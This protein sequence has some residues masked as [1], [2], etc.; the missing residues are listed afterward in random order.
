MIKLPPRKNIKTHP[1]RSQ[2]DE[3]QMTSWGRRRNWELGINIYKDTTIYKIDNQQEPTTKLQGTRLEY[4][5]KH[6]WKM[7]L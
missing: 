3:Y 4:L 2:A 5:K 6:K 7:N 1:H